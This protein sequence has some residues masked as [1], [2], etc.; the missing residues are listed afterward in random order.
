MLQQRYGGMIDAVMVVGSAEVSAV[1][2]N[3]IPVLYR[4]VLQYTLVYMSWR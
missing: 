2:R 4:Y 1:G 3:I